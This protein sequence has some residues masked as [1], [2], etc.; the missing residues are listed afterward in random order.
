MRAKHTVITLQL[1]GH[2]IQRRAAARG[3]AE[4]ANSGG[5]PE[6]TIT[7]RALHG[8]LGL[9]GEAVG[10]FST[11]DPYASSRLPLH[12]HRE[13]YEAMRG[14]ASSEDSEESEDKDGS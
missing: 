13:Q 3:A 8:T 9:N 14:G 6:T 7:A 10:L 1:R 2:E 12:Y 4:A 11:R 5:R